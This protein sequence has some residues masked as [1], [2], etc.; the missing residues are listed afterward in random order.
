[1]NA[2]TRPSPGSDARKSRPASTNPARSLNRA[3]EGE[4]TWRERA[5]NTEDALKAAHAEILTQ[6]TQIGELT[7]RIRDVQAEW[8]EGANQRIT[9]ELGRCGPPRRHAAPPPQPSQ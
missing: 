2:S 3:N 9:I 4:A 7:G 6:R 8:T 5:L 1:L